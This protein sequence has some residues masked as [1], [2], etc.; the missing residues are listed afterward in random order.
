MPSWD[1]VQE[2]K[3]T[4]AQL[5]QALVHSD[6]D[7]LMGATAA[8]TLNSPQSAIASTEEAKAN[9]SAVPPSTLSLI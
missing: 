4:L 1:S 5:S 2:T 9:A 6:D 8:L 7:A 3:V